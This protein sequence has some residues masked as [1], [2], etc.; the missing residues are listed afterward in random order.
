MP[1]RRSRAKETGDQ[2]AAELAALADGSLAPIPFEMPAEP[3]GSSGFQ[4]FLIG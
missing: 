2:E 3:A 1:M 4:Q